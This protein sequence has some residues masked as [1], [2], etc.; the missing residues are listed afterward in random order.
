MQVAKAWR[1]G[2]ILL[3]GLLRSHFL[4]LLEGESSGRSPR[5]LGIFNI[6]EGRQ[7]WPAPS[8]TQVTPNSIIRVRAYEIRPRKDKHGVDP[9]SDALQFRCRSGGL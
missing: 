2:V 1:A 4:S 3:K 8:P 7:A 6:S 9:I 5:R